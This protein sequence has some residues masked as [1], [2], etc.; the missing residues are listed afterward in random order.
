M[1][2]IPSLLLVLPLVSP[3]GAQAVDKLGFSFQTDGKAFRGVDATMAQRWTD[4]NN[5]EDLPDPAAPAHP[6]FTLHPAPP[7]YLKPEERQFLDVR[8][9]LIPLSDATVQD[10]AKA[11]SDLTTA[12]AGVRRLLKDGLGHPALNSNLP[13]WALIDAGQSFHAKVQVVESEWASGIAYLTQEVQDDRPVTNEG[14]LLIFQGVSQD[15]RWFISLKAPV[16]HPMLED[17]EPQ[18]D[19]DSASAVNAYLQRMET[20]L[21]RAPEASFSPSLSGLLALVRSIRPSSAASPRP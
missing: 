13:E 3:L 12:S 19:W 6:V 11:Y 16:S 21:D 5:G 14:L 7:A 15:G 20:R 10:F 4:A 2:P 9:E 8:L 17:P 18:I 1:K